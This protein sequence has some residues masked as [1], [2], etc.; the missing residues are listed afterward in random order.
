MRA[1]P[2]RCRSLARSSGIHRQS[3]KRNGARLCPFQAKIR[4]PEPVNG[5]LA[6][7]FPRVEPEE[8]RLGASVALSLAASPALS[9]ALANLIK[10]CEV[11]D[12]DHNDV[13]WS[14]RRTDIRREMGAAKPERSPTGLRRHRMSSNHLMDSEP[15]WSSW[16]CAGSVLVQTGEVAMIE[17]A[18]EKKI[19]PLTV[20]VATAVRITGLS[21]SRIYELIQSGDLDTVKV[22]RATLIQFQSL[23]SLTSSERATN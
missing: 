6:N 12:L 3:Q 14:Q 10:V 19:E 11:I 18:W 22:G 20:R 13:P 7:S 21:R 23:K 1:A 2:L 4:P 8:E 9:E 5:S 17:R 16:R 15:N